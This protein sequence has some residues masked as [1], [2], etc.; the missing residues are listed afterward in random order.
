MLS[1]R[2]TD[3]P[4]Y[5]VTWQ[6]LLAAAHT[7]DEVIAAARD[8]TAKFDPLT[9]AKMPDACKPAKLVDAQDIAAYAYELARHDCRDEDP[10]VA[11]TIRELGAFFPEAA[12]RLAQLA[13][14]RPSQQ[15]VARLFG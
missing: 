5:A 15:D 9:L 11:Q 12:K 10:E 13:S 4:L 7:E 1:P 3:A 6:Q 2:R 8:F 14:P